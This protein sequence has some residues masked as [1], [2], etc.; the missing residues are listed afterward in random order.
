MI[1]RRLHHL[2]DAGPFGL[3]QQGE[4][5]LLLGHSLRPWFVSLPQRLG[6]GRAGRDFAVDLALT[7]LDPALLAFRDFAMERGDITLGS[8][9]SRRRT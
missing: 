6:G 9:G 3:A 5:A 2:F 1:V 8:V 7:F 4:H